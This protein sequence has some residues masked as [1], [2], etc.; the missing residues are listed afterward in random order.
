MIDGKICINNITPK[1]DLPLNCIYKKVCIAMTNTQ[2][3]TLGTFT[4]PCH[5]TA[6]ILK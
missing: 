1:W 2:I 4:G 3:T 5:I 6:I